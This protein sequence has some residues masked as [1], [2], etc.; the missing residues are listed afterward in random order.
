MEMIS[1]F[2]TA[3]LSPT[4]NIR[5]FFVWVA[6]GGLYVMGGRFDRTGP[7]ACLRSFPV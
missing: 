2:G 4:D 1:V 3:M 7:L 5:V 6:S